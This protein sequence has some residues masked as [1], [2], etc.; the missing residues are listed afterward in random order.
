MIE[1]SKMKS[2]MTDYLK[3][4][5]I[6]IPEFNRIIK[7]LERNKSPLR[8]NDCEINFYY[9]SEKN[10]DVAFAIEHDCNGEEVYYFYSL[11]LFN[12]TNEE[13]EQYKKDHE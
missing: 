13:L 7:I 8:K 10:Q 11:D 12:K 6:L 9:N 3:M 4:K 1:L 2:Y 5:E